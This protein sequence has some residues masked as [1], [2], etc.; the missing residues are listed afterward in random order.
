MAELLLKAKRIYAALDDFRW[1]DWV[2]DRD[3]AWLSPRERLADCH[4]ASQR[5][6]FSRGG[7]PPLVGRHLG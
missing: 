3:L 5:G 4:L 1:I 2:P 7:R 6:R